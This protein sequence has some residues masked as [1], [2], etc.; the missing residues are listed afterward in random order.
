V[1]VVINGRSLGVAENGVF[2]AK[3]TDP[4]PG[5]KLWAEAALTWNLM[6]ADYI[7]DGGN[8][9]DFAP[10][11]PRSSARPRSDQDFFW[12]QYLH[13]GGAP[14]ARPYTSNHGWG[15][16]VDVKTKQAAAWLMRHGAKYGWSWDEGQR[17]GEWWHWR[18][19]GTPSAAIKR[20]MKR[21]HAL[22]GY[23]E[24]EKRWI[25]EYDKLKNKHPHAHRVEVLR[26]VMT[27]QRKRIW[28][29]A[30]SKK[31]GGDGHGWTK[32]RKKRYNSLKR[33]TT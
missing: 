6:V 29:V 28:K 12:D 30:Q 19:V 9:G 22:D 16:A 1:P 25:R 2:T 18:Y 8:P 20:R 15:I 11:G 33:R 3:N 5:G 32:L 23:T 17:V 7:G 31:K 24:S 27:A 4:I 26:R 10:A 21:A 13:H 14:A